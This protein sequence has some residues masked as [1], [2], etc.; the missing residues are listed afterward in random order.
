[1]G[2]RNDTADSDATATVRPRKR[3]ARRSVTVVILGGLV[4]VVASK[5]IRSKL[6]DLVF[7]SEEEFTYSSTTAPPT[8][9]PTASTPA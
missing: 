6:L 4:A 7:G 1:M 3:W 5:E 9:A 2:K 8:P